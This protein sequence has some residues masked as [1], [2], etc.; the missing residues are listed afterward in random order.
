MA[1]SS[2]RKSRGIDRISRSGMA[3][4]AARFEGSF[5][6]FTPVCYIVTTDQ[7]SLL[8]VVQRAGREQE[9]RFSNKEMCYF[10]SLFDLVFRRIFLSFFARGDV[11]LRIE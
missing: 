6:S 8:I 9:D 11:I 3:F 7:D 2:A 10:T 4:L 5:C 1:A